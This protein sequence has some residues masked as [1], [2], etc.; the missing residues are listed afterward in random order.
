MMWFYKLKRSV[1]VIIAVV[2]WLPVFIFCG[3]IGGDIGENAEN[4]Q[5]WQAIVFLLLLAVGIVFT[6]FAVLARKREKQAERDAQ[7]AVAPERQKDTPPAADVRQPSV[8]TMS[9]AA[10]RAPAKRTPAP[11]DKYPTTVKITPFDRRVASID[12]KVGD[13]VIIK[14][15]GDAVMRSSGGYPII[16][17]NCYIGNTKIGLFPYGKYLRAIYGAIEYPCAVSAISKTDDKY[18]IDVNIDLPFKKDSKLPMLTKLNGVTFGERQNA[19]AASVSGD[20]VLVKHCPTAEY[21]NTVE[22]F[23]TAI[24]TSVG[25]IPSDNAEKLLKK[26]KV[27]CAFNGVITSIYGGGVGKNYG[28]D[29]MILSQI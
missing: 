19:L 1:R 12:V 7:P 24:N 29:I 14:Y 4:L 21:P 26:Y 6:V 28:V 11:L 18:D 8:I 10:I 13:A 22:V 9:D 27:G 20:K 17:A 5:T 23:N 3:I 2:A 16:D 15:E 25:V